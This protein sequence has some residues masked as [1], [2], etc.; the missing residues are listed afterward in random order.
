MGENPRFNRPHDMNDGGL[1]AACEG[2]GAGGDEGLVPT[3]DKIDDMAGEGRKRRG[4][5]LKHRQHRGGC[6][7]PK[8]ALGSGSASG[9][10]S[11]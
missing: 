7:M 4:S 3:P 1:E 6:R 8:V 10:R 2:R 5:K 9:G 11:R